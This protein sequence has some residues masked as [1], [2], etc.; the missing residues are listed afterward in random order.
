MKKTLEKLWDEYL[1]E[2]CSKIETDEERCLAKKSAEL[3]ETANALLNKEQKS[4]VEKFVDSVYDVEIYSMR[5][6]FF[7]GCK[8]AFSLILET[9]I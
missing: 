5:K 6:A 2:E 3:H 9:E 8:L 7:K 1:F 4:A